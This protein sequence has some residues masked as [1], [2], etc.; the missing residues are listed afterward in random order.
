[1]ELIGHLRPSPKLGAGIANPPDTIVELDSVASSDVPVVAFGDVTSPGMFIGRHVEGR[2]IEVVY[3]CV[4]KSGF[5][6]SS[7]LVPITSSPSISK[8]TSILASVPT[9]TPVFEAPMSLLQAP[10]LSI[11]IPSVH[12]FLS[13][14]TE[15]KRHVLYSALS[16]V[17][18]S[19]SWIV[20]V[21]STFPT[22]FKSIPNLISGCENALKVTA[23]D[24][25]LT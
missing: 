14:K 8:P 12:H 18:S 25:L 6:S 22:F 24:S 19:G 15:G 4:E 11:S 5:S 23:A 2:G 3:S 17:V 13:L 21:T 9:V 1:M 10:S 7:S 16:V 20:T